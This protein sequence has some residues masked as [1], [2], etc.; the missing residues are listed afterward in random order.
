MN[1]VKKVM[2]FCLP[3]SKLAA[4]RHLEYLGLTHNLQLLPYLF[5]FYSY[6]TTKIQRVSPLNPSGN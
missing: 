2:E 6:P 5:L 1:S 4:G 3:V